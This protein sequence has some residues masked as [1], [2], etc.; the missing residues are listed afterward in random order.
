MNDLERRLKLWSGRVN[1]LS[2]GVLC[3]QPARPG[4][5][6]KVIDSRLLARW[7]LAVG[8]RDRLAAKLV[9]TQARFAATAGVRQS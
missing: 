2:P 6:P 5:A 4:T 7:A 1:R 8:V 9:A 3:T